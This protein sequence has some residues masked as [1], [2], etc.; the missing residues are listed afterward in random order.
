MCTV[1]RDDRED[2]MHERLRVRQLGGLA[3]G[4]ALA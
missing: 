4:V 1:V 2:E 3:V